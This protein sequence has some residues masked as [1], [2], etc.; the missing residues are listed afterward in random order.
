MLRREAVA[1]S[2][3]SGE[4]QLRWH[5]LENAIKN[6][7]SEQ[8]VRAQGKVWSVL[9]HRTHRQ[10]SCSPG[11]AGPALERWPGQMIKSPWE[12]SSTM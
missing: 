4:W 8:M 7:F 12:H 3:E 10:H 2:W 11:P 9:L 6:R 1:Q 5:A